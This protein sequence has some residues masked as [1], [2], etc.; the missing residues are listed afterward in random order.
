MTITKPSEHVA[1]WMRP[2]RSFDWHASAGKVHGCCPFRAVS[3]CE[4]ETRLVDMR[5]R[6]SRDRACPVR[7]TSIEREGGSKPPQITHPDLHTTRATCSRLILL[8]RKIKQHKHCWPENLPEWI[9]V[10][11][12]KSLR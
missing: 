7:W 9:L 5:D 1:P 11:F 10:L 6:D 4:E 3:A 2:L 8:S 12:L